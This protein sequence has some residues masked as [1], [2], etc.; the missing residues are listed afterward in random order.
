M[1]V[2]ILA[3]TGG[4]VRHVDGEPQ[5]V[6]ERPVTAL[7]VEGDRWW[8]C[9]DDNRILTDDAGGHRALAHVEGEPVT[10]LSRHG[11]S[12]LIGTAAARL[13]RLDDDGVTP[14]TG[15]DAAPGRDAWH[16][17]WGGPPAVR[18]LAAD[19]DTVYVNVHVGGIVRSRDG[20]RS[21]EP[22]VD[23]DV[24][25][26]EVRVDARTGT[27]LAAAG[28][29]GL[30]VSGDGGTTWQR[31]TEGLE[32]TYCRAVAVTAHHVLISAS[33]G[34]SGAGAAVHRGRAEADGPLRACTDG[35]PEDLGG[36][37]DT[38]WLDAL[39]ARAVL[40]TAAGDLYVSDDEGASWAL[41][42][43][44]PGRP[45]AVRLLSG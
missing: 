20:G 39:G 44:A 38:G 31:R 36:N 45:V 2:I 29:G 37:V 16:T 34:P 14:V 6:C 21:W 5:R 24:D 12:L 3:T 13:H 15:F 28:A 8:A 17:P 35:L 30:L 19:T 22:T 40:V 42:G 9:D 7:T 25:V 10:A 27:V 11:D 43:R 32:A 23:I 1:P 26:H 33:R 41:S 4:L 18:S